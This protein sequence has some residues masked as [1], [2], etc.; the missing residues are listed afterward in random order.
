MY[1]FVIG[2]SIVSARPSGCGDQIL[3]EMVQCHFNRR[4]IAIHIKLIVQ[5]FVP[6]IYAGVSYGKGSHKPQVPVSCYVVLN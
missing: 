4:Y 6:T 3:N 1:T 5:H 2:Y